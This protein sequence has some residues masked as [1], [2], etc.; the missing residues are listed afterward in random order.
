MDRR[1][2]IGL[3]AFVGLLVIAIFFSWLSGR[4]ALTPATLT[5]WGTM[6]EK[7]IKGTIGDYQKLVEGSNIKYIQKDAEDFDKTLLN[8][9]AAGTGP[10]IWMVEQDN[11]R[12]YFDKI[13]A[14][15]PTMF[16]ANEYR[17]RFV[18]AA[19]V[20]VRNKIVALPLWSDPL[21]LYWNKSMFNTAGIP[22]P[23]KT[24]DSVLENSME[25]KKED[26]AGNIL[27]AGIAMGRA[28]NISRFREIFMALLLQQ[29]GDIA[30]PSGNVM[31]SRKEAQETS[32][33]AVSVTRFYTDFSNPGRNA[34]TW[35][36]GLSSPEELFSQGRLA[37]MFNYASISTDI[38]SKDPHLSFDLAR[39]P[40]TKDTTPVTVSKI[41]AFTVNKF[42][43]DP[44]AAWQFLL[45]LTDKD[46]FSER[47]VVAPA[48][49]SSLSANRE[50]EYWPVLQISSIQSKWFN[51][52]DPS[53]TTPIL[54]DMIE[55]V[56]NGT[57][58]VSQAVYGANLKLQAELAR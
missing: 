12:G 2:L 38:K 14:L 44:I 47:M 18:D 28:D 31:F 55:A 20:Y 43:K 16:S 25:L 24:W 15:P 35:N 26:S 23:P 1:I 45:W 9:L 37:M 52:P 57:Q 30:S 46:V 54:R 32:G 4:N 50:T 39:I 42:T 22:M 33:P 10:D 51:D 6:P 29:G 58:T 5:I 27:T 13:Y 19:N 41:P 48:L 17:E 8:A 3:G 53:K 36:P 21:V 7:Y 11:V 56:A 34:Y 40:Q 49:R